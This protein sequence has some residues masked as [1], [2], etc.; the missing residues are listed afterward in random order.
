MNDTLKDLHAQFQAKYS[1]KNQ[2]NVGG[3]HD[4]EQED[5]VRAQMKADPGLASLVKDFYRMGLISGLR[6]VKIQ[7]LEESKQ[8]WEA[9]P[10]YVKMHPLMP[11]RKNGHMNANTSCSLHYLCSS[12]VCH[13]GCRSYREQK[14]KEK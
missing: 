7:T 5:S 10:G 8:E 6:D 11:P 1:K 9:L 3:L 13:D 12:D 2:A 4:K 14:M